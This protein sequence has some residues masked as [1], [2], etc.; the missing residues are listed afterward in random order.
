MARKPDWRSSTDAAELSQLDRSGFAWE[1]LRRNQ[2]FRD[3]YARITDHIALE[4]DEG[5]NAAAKIARHWGL[6]CRTGP[7]IASKQGNGLVA[8]RNCSD[9][10]RSGAYAKVFCRVQP[11]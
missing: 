10:C 11:P 1:F 9:G 8:P 2:A 3:D 6:V 5:I 7:D 4:T